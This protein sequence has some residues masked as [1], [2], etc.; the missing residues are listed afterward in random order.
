MAR[1]VLPQTSILPLRLSQPFR[2]LPQHNTATAARLGDKRLLENRLQKNS[3]HTDWLALK[4]AVHANEQSCVVQSLISVGIPLLAAAALTPGAAH[5]YT[6]PYP[7]GHVMLGMRDQQLRSAQP[8]KL[9]QDWAEAFKEEVYTFLR[10][11]YLTLL[12]TP[13]LLS[14]PLCGGLGWGWNAWVELLC[15]T[16]TKAGP[17]FIKWGQ[18]RSFPQL[19]FP[20]VSLRHAKSLQCTRVAQVKYSTWWQAML[21]CMPR[22]QVM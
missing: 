20:E 12:F 15:W 6:A 10:G 16:L 13:V 19:L 2:H 7:R 9:F 22:T 21:C 8:V 17:A 14:S 18:V 1:Y 4:G 5:C 3:P 11:L